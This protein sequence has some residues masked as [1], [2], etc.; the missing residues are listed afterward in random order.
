MME[1]SIRG[2]SAAVALVCALLGC[3]SSDSGD[4]TPTTLTLTVTPYTVPAGGDI[5]RCNFVRADNT[6]EALIQAIHT[7]QS[8]GGHHVVVYTVDH[9]IDSGPIE[10]PQGGQFDWQMLFVSGV[11]EDSLSLPEGVGFPIKPNQQFVVETHYINTASS[12]VEVTDSVTLDVLAG[13]PSEATR[14]ATMFVGSM[15]IE[16]DAHESKEVT[17][18]CT[19]PDDMTVAQMFGHTHRYGT[20][21]SA[22]LV[23]GEEETSVY[24]TDDWEAPL[25]KKFENGGLAISSGNQLRV[26]CGFDNTGDTKLG[27]PNE[28]CHVVGFYWPANGTLAC[29]NSGG[30]DSCRCYHTGSTDPGAGSATVTMTVNRSETITGAQGDVAAGRPLYCFLVAQADYEA[31]GF[32]ALATYWGTA[33][34]AELTDSSSTAE[35]A[36]HDVAPGDYQ[37]LCLMDTLYG[38]YWPGHG[39]PITFPY[40]PVTV[41]TDDVNL[42][43][44][45]NFASP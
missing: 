19:I 41:G 15:N 18:T 44:T 32:N 14:A 12:D 7:N 26:T 3:S 8:T 36:M 21:V 31:L 40:T 42:D 35:V 20:G 5:T 29:M 39:T 11:G 6:A 37:A 24:E 13:D 17:A 30:A 9:A 16:V 33:T 38:G 34:D 4:A 22:T 23:Q 43:M 10:C 1:R 45:L 25:V 28:M 2:V 27:Y